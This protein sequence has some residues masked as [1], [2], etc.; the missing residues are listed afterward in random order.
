MS[1]AEGAGPDSRNYQVDFTKIRTELPAFAPQW[2]V[3]DGVR[4]IYR[5]MTT[6]GVTV[7]EF[8]G[9]RYVRL[10]KIHELAAARRLDLA[11]LRTIG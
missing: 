3:P 2:T 4:Q 10:E 8:E 11:T 5:D 7:S 6:R 9:P 1:F